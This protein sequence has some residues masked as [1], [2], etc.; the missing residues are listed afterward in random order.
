[1]FSSKNF[2]L[3]MI[4]FVS[5]KCLVTLGQCIL[6]WIPIYLLPN[7]WRKNEWVKY[8]TETVAT[9]KEQE[10]VGAGQSGDAEEIKEQ[11]TG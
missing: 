1:M 9:T 2:K 11:R 10:G 6:P 4:L 3:W 5:M 7:Q 8:G